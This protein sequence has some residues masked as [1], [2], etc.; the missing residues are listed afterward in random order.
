MTR[1]AQT[2]RPEGGRRI[3]NA[4]PTGV[5]ELEGPGPADVDAA[6]ARI[7]PYV[8][9]TGV[10]AVPLAGASVVAKLEC[11]QR[12]GSFKV[13][14]AANRLLTLDETARRAG[15]VTASS[16]NHGRA[17]ADVAGRLGMR[18][19]VCL[20]RSVDRV[21][22]EAICESGAEVRKD[23]ETYDD[24][25]LVAEQLCATE[26]LTFVHAFDDP[27]VIAGQG[28]LA[29][30]LLA[31]AG[32]LDAVIVPLSGGG[33]ASGVALAVKAR[34][35]D[36][37]VVGASAS[38]AAVLHAALLAGRPVDVAERPTLAGALSGGLGETNRH[39]LRLTHALLDEALVVGES[40]IAAAM[41]WARAEL[42]LVVEGGGAVSLAALLGGGATVA[43]RRWGP[44]IGIVLSGGNVDPAVMARVARG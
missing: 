41:R 8:L 37:K 28:T 25:V 5:D 6:A 42:G 7:A 29:I 23:A 44:R 2:W 18:A 17:I 32:E 13:R 10:I 3:V 31:D 33:L 12:T 34:S 26:G 16:G 19:V 11:R 43:A 1:L 15:V 9:R 24:A 14:G 40:E 36:T 27:A 39:S 21:K 35:P 22:L 20:P 38:H 4:A 30:E